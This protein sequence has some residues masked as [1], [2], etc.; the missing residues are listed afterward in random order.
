[1]RLDFNVL[2]V[3]DQPNAVESTARSIAREMAE[4][5]FQFNPIQCRSLDEVKERIAADVFTDEIDL[6]LVDWD[7]GTETHGEDAI[8]LIRN[9]Q[10][11]RYKD[12]V[13]YSAL[14]PAGEL[15]ELA[16]AN[17]LEG[18]F[19]AASREDLVVEVIGVFE[20]LIKKVLDLNHTRG[21]VMGAT[22]DIDHLVNECLI[23]MHDKLDEPGKVTMLKEILDRIGERTKHFTKRAGKLKGSATLVSL[24]DEHEIFTANDRLRILSRM[25]TVEKFKVY[26]ETRASIVAYLKEVV[27]GRTSLAHLVM[28][29]QGKP[30]AVM[31]S[32]G[33]VVTLEETRVLRRRILS[34]RDDFRVLLA[35]LKEMK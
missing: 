10:R 22:S 23:A 9:E 13:F 25:L 26:G 18:I 20:S 33:K 35:A 27:P 11:F 21:I 19:C 16:F 29:P 3:E 34:L 30:Q 2:W 15:R 17:D 1:M 8:T 7:L 31:T 6:I 24:F 12:I 4:E 32:Q 5:G 28:V 14:K